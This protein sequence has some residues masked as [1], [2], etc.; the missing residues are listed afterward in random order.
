M[1]DERVIGLAGLQQLLDALH[2]R[3]FEVIGPRV[4]DGA[5]VMAPVSAVDDLPRGVGDEQD[6]GHYRLRERGDDALFGFAAPAQAVKP[7]LFPTE[8]VIWRGR[9]TGT[10]VDVH[11]HTLPSAGPY[12]FV[13]VR[14][15]DLQAIAVHDAVLAGRGFTD[16]RYVARRADAFVVA[17]TCSDPGGTCFCASMGG[18]PHPRDGYDLALTE[19]L[20]GEHRFVVEVGSSRGAAVLADLT[21]APAGA[22]DLA[23]GEAIAQDAAGRMGRTLDTDGLRELLYAGA[24]SPHWADVAARCLACTNCTMVCP[25]CFCT[26]VEDISDLTGDVAERHRVWDSCFSEDFAYIHGG[27]LRSETS[28]RYRQ[29]ITHKLG[30]WQDQ[31]GMSGCVGCGRCITWCP[32][33]IDITAE[34]AALRGTPQPAPS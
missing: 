1:A 3:G 32:A 20:D 29:W 30:S 31:F 34:A 24:E 23:A 13:G 4:R 10:D 9:R 6:A 17:I 33:A 19:L 11:D 8:E 15:C 2:A 5:V 28:S 21:S 26:S 22:D 7:V 16:A 12:A 27:S 18:G 25:T 14:P